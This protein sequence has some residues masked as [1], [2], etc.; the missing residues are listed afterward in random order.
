MTAVP[1][2]LGAVIHVN[3][4]DEN[5]SQW[6]S[7]WWHDSS[8]LLLID[9]DEPYAVYPSILHRD[10]HR[11]GRIFRIVRDA[12]SGGIKELTTEWF[13][14]AQCLAGPCGIQ[15]AVGY[16][17]W[18]PDESHTLSFM[19]NGEWQLT[20]SRGDKNAQPIEY[21]GFG[22]SPFWIDESTYG[23]VRPSQVAV[24]GQIVEDAGNE[25]VVLSIPKDS[26]MSSVI[27]EVVH[28]KFFQ[29]VLPVAKQPGPLQIV[30]VMPYPRN[31]EQLIVVASSIQ[32]SPA[33]NSYL[34]GLDIGSQVLSLILDL[35][36]V[37]LDSLS[38]P[39]LQSPDGRYLAFV[40]HRD[41][42]T[43]FYI[44]DYESGRMT[45]SD[46]GLPVDWT[47]DGRWLLFFESGKMVLFSPDT[48]QEIDIPINISECNSAVFTS[49]N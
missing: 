47:D 41:G 6:Q 4:F 40:T 14:L 26:E 36:D 15:K 18:S 29:D 17:I 39:I 34:F 46:H 24:D 1:S 32:E 48:D 25:I 9:D 31:P 42:D 16:P 49:E 37:S 43:N 21:L 33:I 12:Q 44:H 38:M 10:I 5:Q 35:G 2:H 3:S 27:Q 8:M 13:D 23:F 20:L 19:V 28:A 11:L 7:Y 30:S 22:T 45:K